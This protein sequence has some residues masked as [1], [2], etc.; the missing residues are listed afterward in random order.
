MFKKTELEIISDWDTLAKPVVSICCITYNHENYIQK[1]LDSF[2]MQVTTFPF[3]ILVR[4]DCSTDKTARVINKYVNAYPTLIKPIYEKENQYSL[5]IEPMAVLFKKS[6]GCY[7]AL[8]EGDDYWLDPL[9]LQSQV[10]LL[11]RNTDYTGVHNKVEYV[12]KDSIS[13]GHSDRVK[14]N[15]S[16]VNY[17]FIAQQNII[18]TCSFI[19]R[20]NIFD[21][22]V[23]DILNV[24]AFGD[25]VIFLA[26]ALQGKIVYI[27]KTMSAYRKNTGMMHSWDN[28]FAF[29]KK[30]EILSEFN[31]KEK[32]RHARPIFRISKRYL[33]YK[34]SVRYSDE[35]N[36]SLALKHFFKMLYGSYFILISNEYIVSKI[37]LKQHIKTGLC[38]IPFVSGIVNKLI[39]YKH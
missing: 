5:G 29:E 19:F 39:Q 2:L 3:E 16:I 36:Y 24:A 27:D 6:I 7:I 11:E 18:H 32:Y 4:D 15:K 28:K 14:N 31:K 30:L 22:I 26:T 17:K 10:D 21:Q 34:L 23:D 12:N 38:A 25:Y 8:C 9:K 20:R 1:A 33:H 37:S 13:L 35:K